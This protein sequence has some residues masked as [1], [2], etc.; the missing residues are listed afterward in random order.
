MFDE[1]DTLRELPYTKNDKV[2]Q[3]SDDDRVRIVAAQAGVGTVTPQ[4]A[5]AAVFNKVHNL[6]STAQQRIDDGVDPQDGGTH[7]DE[8]LVDIE[9]VLESDARAKTKSAGRGGPGGVGGGD[10][11]LVRYGA[12]QSRQ[13]AGAGGG[14]GR[15][16]RRRRRA[17]CLTAVR[18]R[19]AAVRARDAAR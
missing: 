10:N 12:R 17:R 14:L 1:Y 11:R 4:Q 18:W 5:E 3:L 13:A 15:L 8:L 16:R 9:A 7:A 2:K 6:C 19:G